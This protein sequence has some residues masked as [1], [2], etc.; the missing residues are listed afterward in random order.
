MAKKKVPY[1]LWTKK[2]QN[3]FPRVLNPQGAC[4]KFTDSLNLTLIHD[5]Y[6]PLISCHPSWICSSH[7]HLRLL[8]ILPKWNQIRACICCLL[9]LCSDR[10]NDFSLVSILLNEVKECL[11]I[12]RFSWQG[13]L[14]NCKESKDNA[15]LYEVIL[16][17]SGLFCR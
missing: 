9:S 8:D 12:I 16:L 13:E 11:K 15:G 5:T 2:E 17:F 10:Q 6:L 3:D 7:Y 4:Q 14:N 1:P